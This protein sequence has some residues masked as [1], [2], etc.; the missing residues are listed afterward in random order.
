MKVSALMEK[1]WRRLREHMRQEGITALILSENG[2]TRYVSGYQRYYTATYLPFVHVLIMTMDAGPILLLPRHILGSSEEFV[3]E[4]VIEFSMGQEGRLR[5]LSGVL[6]DL[7]VRS[8]RIGMEFHFVHYGFLAS[9]KQWLPDAEIVNASPM[10]TRVTAVKFEEEIVLLRQAAQI[11]EKGIDVAVKASV[12]GASELDVAARASDFMLREGAEFINHMT[13]RSGPHA[14]GNFPMP[15]TR[16][17]QKGDCVMIDIGCVFQGYVS[18]INRTVVVGV[19]T[20]G[21]R[22]LMRVGQ[23]MLERGIAAVRPGVVASKVWQA[24][25]EVAKKAGM[26]DRVA[27]P[28]TGH[29]IGIGLHEEPFITSDSETVLEEGMVLGVEP[30]VYA[31]GIGGSRPED[32]V[33]VTA[34]GAELLTH[35]PRDY[36]LLR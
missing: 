19:P 7:G 8:K 21:Q 17:I 31:A 28:F 32:M 24:S 10:M 36:E 34:D 9:L 14:A 3:A 20:E 35:Y 18:D 2:R 11:A 22:Q 33:L 13:I 25:F 5:T 26:A 29:G 6:G 1:K 16:K 30:G 4:K 12:E 23:E 27:I 15:T